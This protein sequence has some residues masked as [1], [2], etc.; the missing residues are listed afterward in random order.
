MTMADRPHPRLSEDAA[1][2][3]ADRE[4]FLSEFAL[5]LVGEADV[6]GFLDWS[7]G[8]IGRLLA[9]DRAGLYLVEGVSRMAHVLARATWTAEG[10]AGLPGPVAPFDPDRVA[11]VFADLAPIATAD[12]LSEPRLA[13]EADALRALGTKSALAVPVALGDVPCGFLAA[14]AVRERRE[15]TAEEVAFLQTAARHLSAALR[16]I[17]LLEELARQRDRVSI[18][19][20]VAAA[21]QRSTTQDEV[22]RTALDSLRENLGFKAAFFA[23]L[24][25]S[26]DEAVSVGMYADD[27]PGADPHEMTWRRRL[28]PGGSSPK[29]LTV[30]VLRSGQAVVVA[31]V[32]TDPRAEASRPLLRRLGVGATAVFPMRAAGRLVGIVAVGGPAAE[33]DVG[34]DDVVL[35]QSLADFVGVAIEQRRAAEAL[36]RAARQERALSEASR[37]LLSRTARRD[38]L[39]EQILDAV[40]HLFGKENCSLRL[41]DR[42]GKTLTLFT[43]RGDWTESAQVSTLAV[44]G[45]GIVAAAARDRS[46]LNVPDVSK[47]PRYVAGWLAARSE[48]AVPLLLDGEVVGVLDLQSSRPAAFSAEDERA[49]SAFAERAAL[50]LRLADAV[51]QLEERKH[52]LEVV[53]RATQLLNFRLHT[54]DVLSSIVEES[55]RAF[56]GAVGGVVYVANADGTAL[57]VAGASGLGVVTQRAWESAPIP[58]ARL[59][60]AGVAFAENRAVLLEVA[61]LDELVEGQPAEMRARGRAAVEDPEIR[62]LMAVP[63]RVAEH[64]LG[65]LE[66]LSARPGV[67]E[68]KDADTLGLLAEQSA[69]ALRNARLVEELQRSNRL[70]DDFL[71]N[72]SHEVRTPLTGIVGWTEVL[73]DGGPKDAVS[74]RALEAILGQAATL[75]RMLTDLIDLSRIDNFGLEIRHATV[76][77]AET[78]AAAFDAVAPSAKKKGVPMVCGVAEDL[79]ALDGDPA[80]LQQVVWNLLTNAVKFSPPGK[81]VR[82]SARPSPDEGVELVVED[83]GAGID[84]AFLPHV[85]DRFRQEE[86]SSSRRYGGLGVGLSIARAI[87]EAHGGSI[88]AESDGRDRGSRFRVVFPP[89]RVVSSG[90]FRRTQLPGREEGPSGE[91]E[92]RA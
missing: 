39:L 79:P 21:V 28:D 82:L 7:V 80:R 4:R 26:G 65:V 29:E 25:P 50:A 24:S 48:L 42:E 43:R 61:G 33:W 59:R 16:Q 86:T 76:H 44:D 35:L 66:V 14:T 69:I 47:D 2:L 58:L 20:D 67:F 9:A 1:R 51:T 91:K 68:A 83:E 19:L 78:I 56:P 22:I 37:A 27:R 90:M 92:K 10:V 85:F 73:L 81:T 12:V 89:R 74:R 75:S 8:E 70:K 46:V 54:P 45:P 30:Q 23:L 52:V 87:V 31:D 60:C 49:L 55:S 34:E 88:E 64:R 6:P 5:A 13:P 38:V 41:A 53:T 72:F 57:A 36:S 17:G 32:E 77:L 62:Q 11:Q 18:L 84:A 15:W 3:R 71:A 63:I 40:V